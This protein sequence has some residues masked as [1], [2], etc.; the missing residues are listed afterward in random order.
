VYTVLSAQCLYSD[1]PT[2]I[3]IIIIITIIIIIIIIIIILILIIIIII[4][5][6]MSEVIGNILFD[7]GAVDIV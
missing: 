2:I 1:L 6:I 5:I 4:I 7:L 3:I